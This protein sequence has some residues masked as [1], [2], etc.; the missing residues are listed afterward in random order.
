MS[1]KLTS[2]LVNF[3]LDILDI[4]K[5][6]ASLHDKTISKEV[7]LMNQLLTTCEKLSIAYFA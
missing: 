7:N 1:A 2:F 3:V 5:Q 6:Y 4:D